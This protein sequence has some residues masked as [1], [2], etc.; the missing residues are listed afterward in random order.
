MVH[1]FFDHQNVFL[2]NKKRFTHRAKLHPTKELFVQ[3][4]HVFTQNKIFFPT[5]NILLTKW[6]IFHPT[7]DNSRN[8]RFFLVVLCPMPFAFAKAS[9]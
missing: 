1:R 8:S 2:P 5:T 3:V 6:K 4:R 9:E 7:F